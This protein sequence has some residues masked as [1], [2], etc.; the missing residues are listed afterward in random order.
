MDARHDALSGAAE[1]VLA[2]ERCGVVATVGKLEVSPNAANVIP[3]HVSFT[4]DVRHARDAR[5]LAAV[6][7]LRRLTMRIA[8]QRRLGATWSVVQDTAAVRC[9]PGWTRLLAS[10]AARRGL[11]AAAMPSGAGHDA[12]SMSAL[13]PV[14]MLFV[15]CKGG[16]SHHPDESVRAADVAHAIAVLSDFVAELATRHA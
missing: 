5:R 13:G 9:D 6:R 8:R 3:G 14:A 7:T 2:V 12:V 15:R 16:V 11:D 4:I 10:C 1:V